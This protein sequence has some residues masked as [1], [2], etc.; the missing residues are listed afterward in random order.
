MQSKVKIYFTDEKVENFAEFIFAEFIINSAKKSSTQVF[1][2]NNFFPYVHPKVASQLLT[3][4][5][6]PYVALFIYVN[7][8]HVG[9]TSATTTYFLETF[10]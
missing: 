2:A 4:A 1:S 8:S 3:I 5:S 7:K 6:L 10:I 9:L